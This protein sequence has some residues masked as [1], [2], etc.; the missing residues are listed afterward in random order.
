[1]VQIEKILKLRREQNEF[2]IINKFNRTIYKNSKINDEINNLNSLDNLTILTFFAIIFPT[3]LQFNT[4]I[5][6][7]KYILLV[8]M[9]IFIF[10]FTF[11]GIAEN[12]IKYRIWAWAYFFIYII[13]IFDLIIYGYFPSEKWYTN[14]T[15]DGNTIFTNFYNNYTIFPRISSYL[16]CTY[17]SSKALIYIIEIYKIRIPILSKKT[18]D[19]MGLTTVV[20]FFSNVKI[21]FLGLILL[22]ISVV[23]FFNKMLDL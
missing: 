13:L 11:K 19:N 7:D 23:L 14:V 9:L 2:R 6:Y 5:P 4:I 3:I 1:M 18:I 12:N 16:I 20:S 22:I 21:L 10:L 17:F 8:L 15:V